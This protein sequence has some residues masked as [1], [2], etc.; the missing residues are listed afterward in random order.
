MFAI[1]SDGSGVELLHSNDISSYLSKVEKDPTSVVLTAPL[2]DSTDVYG[3]TVLRPVL[4]NM[5]Q[6]WM[7]GYLSDSII[8]AGLR[9]RDLQ[10]VSPG[11]VEIQSTKGIDGSGRC[12]LAKAGSVH[13]QS[14]NKVKCPP[15]LE[16]RQ[17]IKRNSM[18]DTLRNQ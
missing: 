7:K 16:F 1:K 2:P 17:L 18:S 6:S 13:T 14:K 15:V 11:R 9:S 8:P 10:R 3:I 5:S 4:K 12:D